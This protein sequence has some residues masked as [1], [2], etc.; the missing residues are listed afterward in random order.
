MP[1][2]DAV[3]VNVYVPG[4]V[5][6][7]A[8]E[9]ALLPPHDEIPNVIA[10]RTSSR[11]RRRRRASGSVKSPRHNATASFSERMC[12]LLA[13]KSGPVATV[14]ITTLGP[15]PVAC[16]AGCPHAHDAPTGNPEH[17][18]AMFPV[19]PTTCNCSA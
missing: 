6:W 12:L 15:E 17:A 4:G 18:V 11:G 5:G 19:Y 2:P 7:A 16:S 10:A 3:T 8:A 14:N 1:P 9:D 13:A